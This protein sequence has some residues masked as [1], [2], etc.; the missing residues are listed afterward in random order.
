VSEQDK[1]FS[2]EELH[3]Y[4]GQDGRPT[5]VAYKGVVYDVSGS[6]MWRNGK[7]MNRHTAAHDL[8]L[9][10]SGAPHKPDVL[11]RYPRVGTLKDA[12]QGA[13][14]GA[15]APEMPA[16][17]KKH[18]F[19]HRHPHP[20]TV[21]FPIVFSISATCFTLLYLISGW[22]GFDHAV[23]CSLG[24]G[25]L[26]TPVAIATGFF[27]W[28]LNYGSRIMKETLMKILLSPLLLALMLWAFVIRIQTPDILDK[29]VGESWLYILLTLVMFPLAALI[30]WFGANLTFPIH[31]EDE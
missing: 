5:Y 3:R 14:P 10:F 6:R 24:G 13:A 21:H 7:H 30:G 26:L 20:M 15:R 8:T 29:G 12:E 28:W 1:V 2:P 18:P 19:L 25:V 23:V 9:E 11:E 4:D 22:K 31:K 17:V 16:L 27:T